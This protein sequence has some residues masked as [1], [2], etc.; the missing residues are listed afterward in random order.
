[1]IFDK[2]SIL[3]TDKC[4]AC[5]DMCCLSCSPQ[6]TLHLDTQ[7]IKNVIDEAA[8]FPEIKQILFTGGEALL[9]YDQVLECSA[10]ARDRGLQISVYTNGFWGTSE[11]EAA[12]VASDLKNSGVGMVHFSV[13]NYHQEWIPAENVLRAVHAV[14]EAG[15]KSEIS[16]M[17]TRET[18]NAKW[19]KELFKNEL[20]KS[21]S[22]WWP[23]LPAGRA[24]GKINR[25]KL[26]NI[27]QAKK[28]L[29]YFDKML[30]MHCN[31]NYY[32]CCSV[33][34]NEIP[35]LKIGTISQNSLA[36]LSDYVISD[37]W[38]F[39]MLNIGFEWFLNKAE[40]FGFVFP[41][42]VPCPCEC[43]RL[44]FCNPDLMHKLE[45]DVRLKADELRQQT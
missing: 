40:E 11:Q 17:E 31:G 44:I 6:N 5:C 13:D 43:C 14:N 30:L 21:K 45:N 4:N 9:Y 2:I 15:M 29:C 41:E 35:R 39:I 38:F 16:I 3:L 18:N 8:G 20:D 42:L 36:E 1:M 19:V 32:M 10:Y 22:G 34:F 28:S 24:K 25:D 33:Y 7:T 23:L 26:L 12:R 27:F 37:D